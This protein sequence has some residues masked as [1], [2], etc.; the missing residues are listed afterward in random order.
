MPLHRRLPKRG[1]HNIFRVEYQPVNLGRL[2]EMTDAERID[3]DLMV[4]KRIIR[5]KR[6]PVKVLGVGEIGRSVTIV[7]DAASASAIEKIKSAGGTFEVAK[8]C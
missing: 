7:A 6:K 3:V 2:A 5:H 8:T 4:Q 1:F